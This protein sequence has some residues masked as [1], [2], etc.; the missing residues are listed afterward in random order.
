M[1]DRISTLIGE[2]KLELIKNVRVLILG[3]G[4][5]GGYVIEALVR[6]GI[7]NITIVDKD[8]VDES[9]I[10]RQIIALHSTIG[11]KKTDVFTKRL[12]DINP[13]I[14]LTSLHL[15]LTQNNI[16]SLSLANY[17]YVVD[18]IDDVKVKVALIKYAILNNIKLITS[19]GTAKKIDASLLKITRLDKTYAD[20]LAKKLRS[21][22]RGYDTKK[23]IALSSSEEVLI[24]G[25]KLGSCIFVPAVGGLLI[26]NYI[27]K[28]IIKIC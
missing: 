10:N 19:C 18:A 12:T 16:E 20:P 27:I 7:T 23:I 6:S 24:D 11:M 9:N 17:D 13:N 8:V 22:L 21:E 15:D 3:C 14:N 4:G 5:V 1:F 25:A 28:D 2:D 26:A